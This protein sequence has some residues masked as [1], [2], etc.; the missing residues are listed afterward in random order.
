MKS[1]H[2]CKTNN[3]LSI[4][5]SNWRRGAAAV[6]FAVSLSVLAMFVFSGV[7]F[8]RI[9]I[10]RHNADCAAYEA[11]R[12]VIVPGAL[13]ADAVTAA[14]DYLN[15]VGVTAATI[16]VSPNPIQETTTQI[17]VQVQVPMNANAW[18]LPSFIHGKTLVGRSRL[19]TERAPLI[20]AG[21]MPVPPPPAPVP[22][23][24]PPPPEPTPPPPPPI[25]ML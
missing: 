21:A 22:Q 2:H 9:S 18:G 14:N 12:V 3:A 13:H 10:L 4:P 25:P 24:T 16:I 19:M 23:P 1:I 20:L 6:E 15:R 17:E 5:P 11:A 7:E 8:F